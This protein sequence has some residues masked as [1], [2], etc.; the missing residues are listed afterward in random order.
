[1]PPVMLFVFPTWLSRNMPPLTSRITSTV[2]VKALVMNR[3]TLAWLG[4]PRK[5]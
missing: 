1:M 4:S 2:S 3:V 5:G